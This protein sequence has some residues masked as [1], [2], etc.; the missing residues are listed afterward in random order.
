MTAKPQLVVNLT[1]TRPVSALY[2][3]TQWKLVEFGS[4]TARENAQQ[5]QEIRL[6]TIQSDY[7]IAHF[8]TYTARYC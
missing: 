2:I 7:R 3:K 8:T 4:F 5:F 1:L 6:W